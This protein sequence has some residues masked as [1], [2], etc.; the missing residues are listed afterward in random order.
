[1][2]KKMMGDI[3]II[4][5]QAPVKKESNLKMTEPLQIVKPKIINREPENP[6]IKPIK[7]KK[8]NS[9]FKRKLFFTILIIIII[10]YL[11]YILSSVNTIIVPKEDIRTITQSVTLDSWTKPIKSTIMS[12]DEKTTVLKIE[13]IENAKTKLNEKIKN[14]LIYDMPDNYILMDG[15]KSGISY[16]EPE[17]EIDPKS[18]LPIVNNNVLEAKMNVLIFEKNSLL[19]YLKK[20]TVTDDMS[21]KDISGLSCDL[22]SDIASDLIMSRQISFILNGEITFLP[23]IDTNE[24]VNSSSFKTIK[25]YKLMLDTNPKIASYTI[26][27]N[28]FPIFP[29]LPKNKKHIHFIL[30]Q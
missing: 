22:R 29:I 21:V 28:P 25:S 23:I 14:R 24:L 7:F 4:R 30:S 6:I 20:I 2:P 15:C 9:K 26:K 18:K 11:L 13:D 3:K 12:I 17:F 10:Y 19:N 16:K 27:T 1:M 5:K 8:D